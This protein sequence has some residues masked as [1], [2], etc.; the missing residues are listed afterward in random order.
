MP[1]EQSIRVIEDRM[2]E[3][4][5]GP[6]RL[7]IQAWK[8]DA[9][10]IGLAREAAAAS[11]GFLER[12]AAQRR[13]LS[14]AAVNIQTWPDDD[15]AVR[16]IEDTLR[17]GDADLTP[18]AT[19]AG[20]IADAVA[21]WLWGQDLDR[22]IV[23]NGGDIALRMQTE[24]TVRV[25]MRP[26]VDEPVIS[27]ILQLDGSR[28]SWGVTTSGFGGRSLSRGIA[29]AVICVA[30][31]AGTADAASTAIANACWAED[32]AVLRVLARDLDPNTDIPDVPVTLSFEHINP[33]TWKTAGQR[34]FAR[35]GQLVEDSILSGA[36]I[37]IGEELLLSPWMA[38]RMQEY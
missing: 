12:I 1:F 30:G 38:E 23:E 2:V 8:G 25:G 36:A 16:M 17:I 5:S 19:V 29:S 20:S 15:L 18:M 14:Q 7:T 32:E 35:A 34:G 21:D 9:P 24:Q 13:I 31:R 28:E 4:L 3:A 26:R 10:Q 33:E 27:H 6:M 37:F 11:F 22:V